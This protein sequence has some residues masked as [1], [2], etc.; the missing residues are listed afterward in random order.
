MGDERNYRGGGKFRDYF[1]RE[2]GHTFLVGR[3]VRWYDS[4]RWHNGV[5]V[6]G[7]RQDNRGGKRR[8][9]ITIENTG[10]ATK[11]VDSGER[12]RAYPGSVKKV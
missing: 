12:F 2:E 7:I 11:N 5:V 10:V 3:T 8:E 9:Y 6:D 1:T 4:G